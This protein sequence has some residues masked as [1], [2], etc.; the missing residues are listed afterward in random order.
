[1]ID[2]VPDLGGTRFPFESRTFSKDLHPHLGKVLGLIASQI[3]ESITI[4]NV[5][6]WKSGLGVY[7]PAASVDF[8]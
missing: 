1:M 6:F 7:I 5:Q 3:R 4:R 8:G 2:L